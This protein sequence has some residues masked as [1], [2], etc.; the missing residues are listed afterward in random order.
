[1]GSTS[2]AGT[3]E[4][5]RIPS[6]NAQRIFGADE[7]AALGIYQQNFSR[8]EALPFG[9]FLAAKIGNSH[10]GADHQQA[11]RGQGVTHRAQTIAVEFRADGAAV[12]EDQRCRTVPCFLHAGLLFQKIAQLGRSL[13]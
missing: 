10:L 2:T 5:A 13:R 9:N 11:V 12:G 6:R 7:L 4:I 1:M 3:E 8:P